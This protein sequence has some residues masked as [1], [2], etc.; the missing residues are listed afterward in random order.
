MWL[1]DR[2]GNLIDWSTQRW[3]CAT[4]RRVD[5]ATH[6][7]LD[8]PIGSTRGVGL[9]HFDKWAAAEG[10]SVARYR[11]G[12]GLLP[13]FAALS[14]PD[15]DA[16]AVDPAVGEFYERAADFDMDVWS[17]WSGLFRPFGFLVSAIFSRRLEQL[18]LPLSSLDTSWGMTS[19]VVQVSDP[20]SGQLRAN[21][22]V[23]TLV[24]TGRIIYVGSYSVA[25]PPGAA[26]PCVKTVFPLPNGNAIVILRPEA[27]PDGS[28][29]L[30]SEGRRFGDPGF[31]FTVHRPDGS[32]AARYLR[33]FRERIHVYPAAGGV[34]R[35]DHTMSL[36]GLR[37]LH[38]HYRLRRASDRAQGPPN[39]VLH[40]TGGA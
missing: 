32:A 27:M 8:G 7:W 6:P 21:A 36:W 37:C 19:E 40:L 10:L 15:F 9:A 29:V 11:S 3:V 17:E 25:T 4:G 2:R 13:S 26:G 22:W 30:V 20:A 38:L 33:S 12:K 28:L 39:Q 18:N 24:K 23:R 1:G 34:V 5:L 16:S 14:G 31:Y 35:A